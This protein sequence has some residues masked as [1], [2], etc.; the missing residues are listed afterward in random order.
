V[1]DE[2]STETRVQI[3]S[4]ARSSIILSLTVLTASLN[5]DTIACITIRLDIQFPKLHSAD[6]KYVDDVIV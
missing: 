1:H 6:C 3:V 2:N 5:A 4:T